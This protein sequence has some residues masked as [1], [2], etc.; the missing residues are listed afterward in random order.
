MYI[1]DFEC[2]EVLFFSVVI[3]LYFLQVYM[4]FDVKCTANGTRG[5]VKTLNFFQ[6][7]MLKIKLSWK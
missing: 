7:V 4:F 1:L 2:C 5:G 6:N 3:G